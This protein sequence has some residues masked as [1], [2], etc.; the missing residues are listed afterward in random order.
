MKIYLEAGS[1]LSERVLTWQAQGMSL[2]FGPQSKI[3][4]T[5]SHCSWYSLE[6]IWNQ[7]G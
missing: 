4:K 6:N 5:E 1:V 3:N 7:N 2:I